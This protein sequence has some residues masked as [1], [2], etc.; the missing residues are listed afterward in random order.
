MS[1]C[2]ER[3]LK[4]AEVTVKQLTMELRAGYCDNR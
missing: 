4:G 2:D 1:P 3:K